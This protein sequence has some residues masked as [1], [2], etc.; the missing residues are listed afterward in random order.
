MNENRSFVITLVLAVMSGAAIGLIAF[1]ATGQGNQPAPAAVASPDASATAAPSAP[2]PSA[3]AP[4]P[5]APVQY[6]NPDANNAPA[7]TPANAQLPVL[8]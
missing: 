2:S 7:A 4:E 5:M 6:D 3:P 1:G 8:S